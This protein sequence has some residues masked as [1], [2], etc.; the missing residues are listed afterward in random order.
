MLCPWITL[1]GMNTLASAAV[2]HVTN[3]P[4]QVAGL[5]GAADARG[6]HG[7]PS[8]A[9]QRQRQRNGII[10][11]GSPDRRNGRLLRTHSVRP[12]DLVRLIFSEEFWIRFGHRAGLCSGGVFQERMLHCGVLSM[13]GAYPACSACKG[14]T[15][16]G[17][18]NVTG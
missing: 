1:H 4:V 11:L 13:L 18:M 17:V 7:R 15:D 8:A 6:D 12:C 3:R 14:G 9:A 16:A 5:G 10:G 2:E